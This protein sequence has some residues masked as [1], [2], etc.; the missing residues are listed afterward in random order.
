VVNFILE[1]T[2]V[3][4]T[5]IMDFS[6]FPELSTSYGGGTFRVTRGVAV[7]FFVIHRGGPGQ[8]CWCGSAIR[9]RESATGDL[10]AASDPNVI[11][12]TALGL[13]WPNLEDQGRWKIG[14]ITF[15]RLDPAAVSGS[16]RPPEKMLDMRG[17][18]GKGLCSF[19]GFPM[20]YAP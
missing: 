12:L 16:E 7:S 3:K 8:G 9:C 5:L 6:V 11:C 14:S 19:F 2:R 1:P 15:S 17:M 20:P 10:C 13:R 18:R 4:S